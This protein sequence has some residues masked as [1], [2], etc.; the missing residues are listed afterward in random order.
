MGYIIQD[1]YHSLVISLDTTINTSSL[2]LEVYKSINSSSTPDK[3]YFLSS[4]SPPSFTVPFSDFAIGDDLNRFYVRLE[5]TTALYSLNEGISI[6]IDGEESDVI[7]A[8]NNNGTFSV[9]TETVVDD[10]DTITYDKIVNPVHSPYFAIKFN[11]NQYHTVQAVY[12]GNNKL[13]VSVSQKY[14]VTPLQNTSQE[15]SVEGNYLLE[16][17]NLPKTYMYMS[18]F[19]WSWKLTKGGVPVSGRTVELYLPNGNTWTHE[20][21]SEG[22][23]YQRVPNLSNASLLN[24]FRNWSVKTWKVGACY[25][26]YDDPDDY[27]GS[28]SNILT[29]TWQDVTIVKNSAQLSFNGAGTKGKKAQFK[30]KDPQGRNLPNKKLTISVGGKTYNKTTNDSGNVWLLINKKGYKKYKVTFAGDTNLKKLTKTFTE[31]VR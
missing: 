28:K 1:N 20:T 21:D 2:S 18:D 11:D 22:M 9:V 17:V 29:Q 5:T 26:H 8:T 3:V 13:G 14:A 7:E 23:I 30:L 15:V 24:S 25:F 16:I 4:T 10:G 31:T 27:D 6:L 19:E 12:K